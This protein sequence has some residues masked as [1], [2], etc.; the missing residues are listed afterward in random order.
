M[1]TTTE[2][3]LCE[4]CRFWERQDDLVDGTVLGLC[5]RFPPPYDGWP[6]AGPDDWCGEWRDC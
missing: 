1:T 5:R 6:I 3:D 4:R 2:R